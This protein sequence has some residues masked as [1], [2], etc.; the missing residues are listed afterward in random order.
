MK[1]HDN[2]PRPGGGPCAFTLIELLV[3]IA[4]I[5]ILASM[6][7]PALARAKEKANQTH[8]R[9][10]LRE[11]ATAITMYT[12]ENREQLPGPTWSG[13]FF[14]YSRNG[15]TKDSWDHQTYDGNGSLLF[16]IAPYLALRPADTKTRTAIVAQCPSE[17]KKLPGAAHDPNAVPAAPLNVPVSY[18]SPFWITNQLPGETFIADCNININ[19]P[20]GRPESTVCSP[21]GVGYT[22]AIKIT[23]VRRPSECW[24]MADCDYQ[25]MHV[26]MKVDSATYLPY[27]PE[28]PVH[29]KDPGIRNYMF[30]DGSV[31]TLKTTY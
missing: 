8:C 20:F 5:A 18:V 29:G 21:P 31:R 2:R 22:P 6:L 24:G 17:I 14:T 15:I 3:V 27:V 16:Y 10:N 1:T 19:Y 26:G 11:I 28:Y 12:S 13:M 30:L 23:K 4:I 9:S 25:L 7:L